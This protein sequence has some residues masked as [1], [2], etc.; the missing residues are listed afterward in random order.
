MKKNIFI[1]SDIVL[2]LLAKREPFYHHSAS[3]F[4]LIDSGKLHGFVSSLIFSNLFYILRKHNSRK[5]TVDILTKLRIMVSILPVDEKIIELALLSNFN[6]FEDAI[7]YYT[8]KAH[9]IDYIVT[10]NLKDFKT[11]DIKALTAD[12]LLHILHNT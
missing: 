4:S 11:S 6:D 2:D 10:R 3:L 8:A 7:Q 12:Q 1:D 9:K 5:Q